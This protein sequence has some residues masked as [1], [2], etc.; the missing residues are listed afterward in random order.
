M[1]ADGH[2]LPWLAGARG[3]AIKIVSP[4]LTHLPETYDYRVLFVRRPLEEVI[5]SQNAMLEARGEPR[6]ASDQR[7]RAHYAAHLQQVARFL[8]RRSCFTTLHIEYHDVIRD[9][10]AEAARI[11]TFLGGKLDRRGM[12]RV[13]DPSLYRRRHPVHE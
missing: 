6:G 4:L 1:L 13:V 9:A 12:E 8:T 2:S 11:D 10:A 7:M 3:K 5:A